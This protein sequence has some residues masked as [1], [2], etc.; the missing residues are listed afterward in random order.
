MPCNCTA[1]GSWVATHPDGSS[2]SYPNE[3]Q[4]AA[5]VRRNGGSYRF[6]AG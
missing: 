4:A 1:K 5:D 2:A 6:V 3:S